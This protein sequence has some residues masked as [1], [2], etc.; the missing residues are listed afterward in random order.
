MDENVTL[1][2]IDEYMAGYPEDVRSILQQIRMTIRD[3]APEAQETINY[4]VPTFTLLGRNLVHF[5]AAKNH[6]GFYP[7]P[8][9]IAHFQEE[10][11]GYKSAKGSVQ[12][13]LDR[14]I[15]YDLIRRITEFRVEEIR[16]KAK[17]N[18]KQ[19]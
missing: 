10:L 16:A 17:T 2:T 1:A 9:G 15:P 13:P 6:I 4:G 5:G 19:K 8:T 7:T 11:A 12:F 14:P 18:K 3:V